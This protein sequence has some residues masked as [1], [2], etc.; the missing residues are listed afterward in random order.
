MTLYLTPIEARV[1]ACL[2]EKSVTT[3][4][5]YPLTVNATMLAANQKN[6]RQPVMSL[7]EGETGSALLHLEELSLVSRDDRSGRVT[8][9]K[10]RF[11][12]QLLIKPAALAVL[13]TLMLRGAQ[14]AAEL[15]SNASALGGPG[16]AEALSAVLKDLEDR[17]QPL[18]RL[19]P[20]LP[21]QS[22]ARY[23]HLL[24]GE[25]ENLA[26]REPAP[27]R[28]AQLSELLERIEGLEA[29]VSELERRSTP[30]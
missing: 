16:D 1:L 18:V 3:P 4:Q 26:E 13:S 19:L 12:H 25:P 27:G 17:A 14:T 8:K 30:G 21:G 10:H 22:T 24:S 15:R 20:K 23:A 5:Y 2:V 7:S 9:W 28:A 29:R 6:G 11:H